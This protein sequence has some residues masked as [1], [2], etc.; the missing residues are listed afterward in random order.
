MLKITEELRDNLIKYLSSKPYLE[1][2]QGIAEL[3]KLEKI[4]EPKEQKIKEDKK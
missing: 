2:A 4:V 1:V 3:S